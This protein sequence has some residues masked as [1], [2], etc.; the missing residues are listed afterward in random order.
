[1]I[2]GV[3]TPVGIFPVTAGLVWGAVTGTTAGELLRI[4]YRGATIVTATLELADGRVLELTV[5]AGELSVLLPPDTPDGI[6]VVTATLDDASTATLEILLHGAIAVAERIPGPPAGRRRRAVRTIVSP[7]RV[8][9]HSGTQL[10]ASTGTRTGLVVL[11]SRTIA[12]RPPAPLF[13]HVI[14]SSTLGLRAQTRVGTLRM[15]GATVRLTAGSRVAR[16]G[17]EEALLLLD[18][19]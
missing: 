17:V 5:D 18:V 4:R 16:Q 19:L 2:R 12:H 10:H 9:C 11:R 6:A 14:G 15:S 8:V 13:R 1:M 3:T 7:G